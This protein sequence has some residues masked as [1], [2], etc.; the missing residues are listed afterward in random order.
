MA[1]KVEWVLSSSSTPFFL[2]V[3][4]TGG[5]PS[6]LQPSTIGC[7]G[8]ATSSLGSTANASSA[9][10]PRPVSGRRDERKRRGQCRMNRQGELHTQVFQ[11][12]WICTPTPP[13]CNTNRNPYYIQN[14]LYALQ[15]AVSCSILLSQQTISEREREIIRTIPSFTDKELMSRDI[16]QLVQGVTVNSYKSEIQK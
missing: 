2:Q 1:S 7:P 14:L 11:V 10:W 8:T 9:E 4:R 6:T 16:K 5:V 12:P 3:I 15:S 13:F